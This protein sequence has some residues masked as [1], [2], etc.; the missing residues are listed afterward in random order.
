VDERLAKAGIGEEARA[1]ALDTLERV[2][3]VDDERFAA[4]RAAALADRGFGDAYLRHVLEAEGA[5]PEVVDAAVAALEPEAQR[6]ERLAAREGHTAKVAARLQ[7]KGFGQEALE[8]AFG[9][10]FADGGGEA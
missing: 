5:A 3:Y 2:G 9:S 1:D 7:R 4:T 10:L 6:A 8:Q